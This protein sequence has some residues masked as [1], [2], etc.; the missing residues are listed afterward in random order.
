MNEPQIK[1]NEAFQKD[2]LDLLAKYGFKPEGIEKI[3]IYM[4]TYKPSI[5][6]IDYIVQI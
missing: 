1:R 5:V 4:E 6:T 2:L 3:S